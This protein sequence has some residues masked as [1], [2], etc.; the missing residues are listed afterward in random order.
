VTVLIARADNPGRGWTMDLKDMK[1]SDDPLSGRIVGEY[2]KPDTIRLDAFG[3]TL[4][5]GEDIINTM[6]IILNHSPGISNFGPGEWIEGKSF[7]VNSAD[8][9]PDVPTIF[10]PAFS[11]KVGDIYHKGYAMQLQ[12][13]KVKDGSVPGKLYL[14]LPDERKSW[15][16]GSFTLNL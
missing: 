15:L 13:G 16:A 10:S 4:Q 6:Q 2:F 8:R 7:Q 3:L 14:C 12:F 1:P 9:G 5:S 11:K